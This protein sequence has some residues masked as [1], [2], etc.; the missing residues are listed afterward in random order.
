MITAAQYAITST[1]TKVAASTTGHKTVH[2][3][4][5]ANTKIYVGGTNAVTSTTGYLVDKGVGH[6]DI[7][8]G[9]GDELWAVCAVGQTETLT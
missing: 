3:H 9:P 5:A 6:D 2:V 1:P 4:P 7:Y 8:L